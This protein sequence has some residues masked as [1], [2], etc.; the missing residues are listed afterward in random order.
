MRQISDLNEEEFIVYNE[1]IAVLAKAQ[2]DTAEADLT[3]EEMESERNALLDAIAAI[4]NKLQIHP[5][6][7]T[8]DILEMQRNKPH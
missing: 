7:I 4:V 6:Q 2:I 8:Q 5:D 1:C 3:E